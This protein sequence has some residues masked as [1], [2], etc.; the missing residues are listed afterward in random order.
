MN[1]SSTNMELA[2]RL[3][4][5]ATAN[6]SRFGANPASDTIREGAELIRQLNAALNTPVVTQKA[7]KAGK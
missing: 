5:V 7:Q 6:Q 3:E 4:L 1:E 2:E